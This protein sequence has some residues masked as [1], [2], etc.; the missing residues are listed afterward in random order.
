MLAHIVRLVSHS[1]EISLEEAVWDSVDAARQIFPRAVHL[2]EFLEKIQLAV[3]LAKQGGNDLGS[4]PCS[5]A[6]LVRG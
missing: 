1:Q 4:H 3:N 2:P 5:G 6:R